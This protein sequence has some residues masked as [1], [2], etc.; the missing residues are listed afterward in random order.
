MLPED[1]FGPLYSSH[2][3]LFPPDFVVDPQAGRLGRVSVD[4]PAVA[5]SS[6]DMACLLQFL[7]ARSNAR[8]V[9]LELFGKALA[10]RM[11]LPALSKLFNL[12]HAAIDP[13]AAAPPRAAPGPTAVSAAAAT[14]PSRLTPPPSNAPSTPPLHPAT[15]AV[16][17]GAASRTPLEVQVRSRLSASSAAAAADDDESASEREEYTTRDYADSLS[18]R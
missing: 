10:E 3:Q 2:W 1:G 9:I 6:V 13:D 14:P 8:E 5:A 16:T 12:L 4:L 18:S 17:E 15:L 11:P 7:L